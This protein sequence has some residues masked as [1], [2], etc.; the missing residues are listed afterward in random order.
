MRILGIVPARGGSKGIPRKNMRCVGGVPL[1]GHAISAGLLATRV[2]TVLTSTD[3]AEMAGYAEALGCQVLRRPESLARDETPMLEVLRDVVSS[4]ERDGHHYDG[5]VLLQPTAPL[6]T[7]AH[8][9]A[10]L[11]LLCKNVDADSVVSVAAVPGHFHAYWQLT[12]GDGILKRTDGR[13]LA[14]LASRR[15]GLPPVYC[16]NGAI[17]AF[18]MRT[19]LEHGSLYGRRSVP[20]IMDPEESANIDDE[21][22]LVT[23]DILWRLLHAGSMPDDATKPLQEGHR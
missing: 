5:A 3:D 8:V 16:R 17:Y 22:D 14:D 18:R 10:A 13:L 12:I 19:L 4:V 21:M 1:L 11:E 15:Q 9:D 20:Y 6:R 7:A 23:A 2:E